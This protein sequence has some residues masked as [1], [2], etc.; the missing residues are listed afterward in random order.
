MSFAYTKSSGTT[1]TTTPSG[2]P[3]GWTYPDGPGG[4]TPP[5]PD[6]WDFDDALDNDVWPPGWDAS[7]IP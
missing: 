6:D 2:W 3:S 4:A 1:S 7:L 5:W